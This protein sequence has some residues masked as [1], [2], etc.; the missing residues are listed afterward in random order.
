MPSS[1]NYVRDYK[2]E[3]KA[4]TPARKK[5]RAQRMR[6]RRKMEKEGKVSKND[7]KTVE[8]KKPIRS[9]GT[10]SSKNLT[11]KSRSANSKANG[12]KPGESQKGR[13]HRQNKGK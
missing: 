1:P 5:A 2:A 10:N 8:H 12:H 6:A 3:A 4:E 7:G 13:G 9:G 11:T